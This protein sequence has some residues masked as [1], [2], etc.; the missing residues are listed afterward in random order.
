MKTTHSILL[1]LVAAIITFYLLYLLVSV[2]I[3]NDY[4]T[5]LIPNGHKALYTMGGIIR[6]TLLIGLSAIISWGLFTLVLRFLT[7][8]WLKAY[9]IKK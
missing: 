4:L 6:A 2:F 7:F 8:V 1:K 3:Y 9:P 5:S